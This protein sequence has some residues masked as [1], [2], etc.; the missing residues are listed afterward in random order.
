VS[1]DL[2]HEHVS[3]LPLQEIHK[4]QAS[5]YENCDCEEAGMHRDDLMKPDLVSEIVLLNDACS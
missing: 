3:S 4:E 1:A 2:R 5:P